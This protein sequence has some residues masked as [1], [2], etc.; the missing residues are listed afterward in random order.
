[1]T[2]RHRDDGGPRRADRKHFAHGPHLEHRATEGAAMLDAPEEPPRRLVAPL[3][4]PSPVYCARGRTASPFKLKLSFRECRSTAGR[5]T[6]PFW[7][8]HRPAASDRP[9]PDPSFFTKQ[10][11]EVP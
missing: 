10:W 9:S 2:G 6:A 1:M 11:R 7:T 8:S 3:G 5:S 4:V